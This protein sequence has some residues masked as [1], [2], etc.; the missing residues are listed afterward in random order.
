M[1]WVLW[2]ICVMPA[3]KV[4]SPSTEMFLNVEVLW[5]V[6]KTEEKFRSKALPDFSD[7][8]HSSWSV[9]P[10]RFCQMMVLIL[11]FVALG[12]QSP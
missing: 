8:G 11:I 5:W 3:D 2:E 9:R 7:V 12:P 10:L 6:L 4:A 1:A